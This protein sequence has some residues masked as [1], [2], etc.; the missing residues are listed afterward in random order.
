MRVLLDANILISYLL[1]DEDS[2]TVSIV[3]AGVLGQFTLL[4]PEELLEEVARKACN[5]PYLA[6]KIAP[7]SLAQLAAILPDVAETIPK[8]T[9]AI[10]AVTRDP[11]DDYLLAYSL[12][13]QADFLVTGDH[14][15]LS[16][17]QVGDTRIITVGEFWDLIKR[18]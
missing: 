12:V 5:K 1:A 4:L 14:D 3:R 6:G 2:A 7:E 13:G 10:P 8:I 16:L 18:R 15:L 9:D 17:G 11:K